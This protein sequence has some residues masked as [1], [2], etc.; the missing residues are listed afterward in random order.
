MSLQVKLLR[1]LQQG[2]I[3]R[4]GADKLLRVN[5]RLIA[6]TNRDLEQEVAG[7]PFPQRSLPS[8]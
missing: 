4:V 8:S 1:A 6:A 3:Q 7:R 2:E 5:V